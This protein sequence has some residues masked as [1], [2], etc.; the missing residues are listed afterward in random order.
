MRGETLGVYFLLGGLFMGVLEA[1][2]DYIGLLWFAG[3]NVAI[4]LNL[5]GRHIP[6]YVVLGYAFFFGLQAYFIYRAILLGKGTRFF[7]CAYAISWVFDLALQVTGRAFGLYRYYGHQPFLIAG[8][9]AWWF[10]IDATLQLLAGLVFFGLR[11]RFSGWGKL[12]VIPLL[13]ML[14][15][16][17]NGAAGWPVFTA[18]NSNYHADVNGNG[19]TALVYLG[20]SLTVALCGLLVWLVV[21]EIAKAQQRAGISIHPEVTLA[22]VFLAKVGVGISPPAHSMAADPVARRP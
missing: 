2:L 11:E 10:T 7:L 3:D 8:A 15:A 17:L 6:L 5:F 13:P 9:P 19:S 21:T 20:G 4:V 14:Y 22:E 12:I 1:Y 16:G 18:L